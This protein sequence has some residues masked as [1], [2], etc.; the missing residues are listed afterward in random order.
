[1]T[2]EDA[3]EEMTNHCGCVNIMGS[4]EDLV[5]EALEHARVVGVLDAWAERTGTE[6]AVYRSLSQPGMWCCDCDGLSD[7][8]A[9]TCFYGAT[10]GAARAAAAKAIESGEV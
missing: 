9:R 4:I 1:M 10:R 5:F 3:L 8:D 2:P 7:P 6:P